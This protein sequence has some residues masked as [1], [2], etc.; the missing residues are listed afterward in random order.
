MKQQLKCLKFLNDKN[1]LLRF[2]I[3][4]HFQMI[5]DDDLFFIF[6]S[7]VILPNSLKNKNIFI[8][9]KMKVDIGKC[10]T[11]EVPKKGNT[12]CT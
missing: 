8:F 4:T 12:S 7:E 5:K 9:G 2:W 3:C 10:F 11:V 6:F 1:Q